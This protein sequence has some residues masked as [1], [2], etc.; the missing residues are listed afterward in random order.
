MES[1]QKYQL[2]LPKLSDESSGPLLKVEILSA[3][4]LQLD[5]NFAHSLQLHILYAGQIFRSNE[6][7]GSYEPVF[8]FT[9]VFS[10]SNRKDLSALNVMKYCD[11]VVVYL[12]STVREEDNYIPVGLLSTR[13]LV[14]CAVLDFRYAF[15]YTGDYISVELLPCELDGINMGCSPGIIFMRLSLENLPPSDVFGTIS[16][17]EVDEAICSY[18]SRMVRDNQEFYKIARSWWNKTK[19]TYPYVE[20]R[21]IKL[22]ARDETGQHRFVSSFVFPISPPRELN[23]PRFAARF[24]SLIPSRNRASNLLGSSRADE[25]WRCPHALLACLQGDVEVRVCKG[26]CFPFE[27]EAIDV[28]NSHSYH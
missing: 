15:L 20:N 5:Y 18:H 19:K 11:P 3:K 27:C 14:A 17:S 25:S 26:F 2:E 16:A 4:G 10:L 9:S 1:N 6:A 12:T 23:G 22:L 7:P 13:L 8:N 24:V 28:M 21:Q